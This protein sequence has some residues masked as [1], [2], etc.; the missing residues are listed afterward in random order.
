L[1]LTISHLTDRGL[2]RPRNED[3]LAYLLLADDGGRALLVVADGMGG[4]A[5]GDVASGLAVDACSRA[6][7]E[8]VHQGRAPEEAVRES[9]EAANR[10]VLLAQRASP[11]NGGMGTTLTAVLIWDGA[12]VI[13]HC[14]DSRAYLLHDADFRQL[15]SDHSVVGELVKAGQISEDEA[16]VHPQRNLV[17]QALGMRESLEP[18]LLT[19][20]WQ[21][22]DVLLLCTDGL[23]NLVRLQEVREE[24]SRPDFASV[25]RRLVDR[26]LSRGGADN[27]TVLAARREV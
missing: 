22:G 12:A 5:G 7:A 11:A 2:V 3:A 17:T 23:T 4:H 1:A 9:I 26:A 16:M 15:T 25:A 14:G 19:A 10:A 20:A 24:V 21:P 18:E 27:I 6:V 8:A 13:G